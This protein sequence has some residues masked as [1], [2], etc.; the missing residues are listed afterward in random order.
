MPVTHKRTLA[1]AICVSLFSCD[2][3]PTFIDLDAVD[4][5]TASVSF[6]TG[7]RYSVRLAGPGALVAGDTDDDGFL[8]LVY[9]FGSHLSVLRGD[10]RGR[11][12][13]RDDEEL[14]QHDIMDI[15]FSRRLLVA[16][17]REFDSA[18]LNDRTV[19]YTA[20]GTVR[21]ITMVSDESAIH[22]ESAIALE[23]GT[24]I[25]LP[26]SVPFIGLTHADVDQDGRIDLVAGGP[27]GEVYAIRQTDS[28]FDQIDTIPALNPLTTAVV[29]GRFDDDPHRDIAVLGID[30]VRVLL[31][32]RVVDT[33]D[34]GRSIVGCGDVDRDGLDDL[35]ATDDQT[36]VWLNN[37]QAP[38][39]FLRAAVLNVNATR[40]TIA[41]LDQ[42]DRADLAIVTTD[43]IQVYLQ[44]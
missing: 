39:S 15:V 11:F 25:T 32:D 4:A 28:G 34:V 29:G 40:A 27:P 13:T 19:V 24:V 8:D 35:I 1:I 2:P 18:V 36:Y 21:G 20:E 23:D 22:L 42:D 41:D 37:A 16:V 44:R 14:A 5:A 33:T 7:S 43:G 17:R 12:P 3:D 38:G 10:G 6:D 26:D 31:R 9:G 30:R